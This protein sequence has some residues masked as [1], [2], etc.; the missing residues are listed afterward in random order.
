MQQLDHRQQRLAVQ[1]KANTR[2]THRIEIGMTQK[3]V[4]E[5][6]GEPDHTT[7]GK[8]FDL[9]EWWNVPDDDGD[10]QVSVSFLKGVV[11]GIKITGS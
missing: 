6:L 11:S 1:T 9:W 3:Q 8:V 7:A 10:I 5:I 4:V 2:L